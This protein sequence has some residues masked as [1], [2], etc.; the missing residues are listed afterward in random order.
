M[1]ML[2][3]LLPPT[4]ARPC[5]SVS[6]R[7]ED[8]E[9]AAV[10]Y[11][12]QA[13]SLYGEL[14]VRNLESTPSFRSPRRRAGKRVDEMLDRLARECDTEPERL[15]S[16]SSALQLA[17]AIQHRPEMLILDAN[18]GVDPVTTTDSGNT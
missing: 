14:S 16:A 1:K 13:F 7:G 17:V 11:M 18:I 2:T 4:E 3:G 12:S 6:R 5:C 8:M 10:G 9:A 15:R